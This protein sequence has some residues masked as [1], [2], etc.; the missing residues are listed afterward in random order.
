[1]I[2]GQPVYCIGLIAAGANDI[3]D[4]GWV[5]CTPGARYSHYE[6]T[7]HITFK[8]WKIVRLSLDMGMNFI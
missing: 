4:T 7:Q 5:H 1:M 6:G 8:G 2:D 3:S